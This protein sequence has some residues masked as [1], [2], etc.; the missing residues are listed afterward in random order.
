MV[1]TADGKEN[2]K[3][4]APQTAETV[5]TVYIRTYVRTYIHNNYSSLTLAEE[6]LNHIITKND[7]SVMPS[8]PNAWLT[9]ITVLIEQ[10][11]A[12]D[13]QFITLHHNTWVVDHLWCMLHV[14]TYIRTYV[15]MHVL[16]IRMYVCTVCMCVCME[17]MYVC[18][19]G[20][21]VCMYVCMHVCMYVCTR[22]GVP[23]RSSQ[24]AVLTTQPQE[25]PSHL[26]RC[27]HTWSNQLHK[28]SSLEEHH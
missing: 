9:S 13:S 11:R 14:R 8:H 3:V 7:G 24:W 1:S 17:C 21:H 16:H 18:M 15:C 5:Q 23:Q 12:T 6:P 19:Y 25:N 4:T 10:S 27:D 2:S 28:C 22:N 20:M 26:L